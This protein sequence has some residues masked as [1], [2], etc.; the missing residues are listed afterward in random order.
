MIKLPV[1]VVDHLHPMGRSRFMPLLLFILVAY[2]DAVTC[3]ILPGS[4][5]DAAFTVLSTGF[6]GDEPYL[7]VLHTPSYRLHLALL[8]MFH[9]LIHKACK[10]ANYL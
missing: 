10:C 1:K 9:T 5:W 4:N 6:Q 2:I 8:H 7:W 3:S